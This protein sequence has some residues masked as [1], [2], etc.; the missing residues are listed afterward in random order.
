MWKGPVDP[1]DPVD[2]LVLSDLWESKDHQA[3][4]DPVVQ[5]VRREHVARKETAA[6]AARR[7]RRVRKATAVSLVS[8][9]LK[10]PRDMLDH[11]VHKV[12][13]VPEA[14]PERKEIPVFRVLRASRDM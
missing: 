9:D 14:V 3:A 6:P 7:V 11:M 13:W 10:A 2:L 8:V 1:K 12:R 4:V 5:K